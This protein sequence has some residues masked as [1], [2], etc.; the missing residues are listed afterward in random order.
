MWEPISHTIAESVRLAEDLQEPSDSLISVSISPT[1]LFHRFSSDG[2]TRQEATL[3]PLLTV[4]R[5]F[6][7]QG[8]SLPRLGLYEK[9]K[10]QSHYSMNPS[11]MSLE[12]GSLDPGEDSVVV[13]YRSPTAIRWWEQSSTR[14]TSPMSVSIVYT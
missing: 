13:I 14:G 7:R 12:F 8:I 11:R 9:G 4:L 10:F 1:D 5:Q 6:G 2:E 3:E